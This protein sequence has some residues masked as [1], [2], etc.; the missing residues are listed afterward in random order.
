MDF[1]DFVDTF[2]DTAI[3]NLHLAVVRS[4][5]QLWPLP[6]PRLLLLTA[7]PGCLSNKSVTTLISID[8]FYLKPGVMFRYFKN[9]GLTVFFRVLSVN[10]FGCYYS[11]VWP[12]THSCI[13]ASLA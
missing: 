5:Q 6:F 12:H 7:E 8:F 1:L 4:R 2:H 13:S 9:L 11:L 3:R 10:Y